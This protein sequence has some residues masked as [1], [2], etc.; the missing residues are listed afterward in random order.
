MPLLKAADNDTPR[1]TKGIQGLIAVSVALYY[2]Q[3]V[4]FGALDGALGYSV[5]RLEGRWWTVLTHPFVHGGFWQLLANMYALYLFGPRVESAWGTRRFL[6]FYAFCVLSGIIAHSALIHDGVPLTGA[7]AA[8]LGVMV[9]YAMLWPTDEVFVFGVL[10]V[11]VWTAVWSIGAAI[12]VAGMTTVEP[13]SAGPYLGYLVHLAG[14]VAGWA[15]MKTPGA[16]SLEQIRQRVS[17]VPDVEDPPRPIPRSP[18]RARERDETD[19]IVQRSRAMLAQQSTAH[20]APPK[21]VQTRRED[22]DRVLDKISASGID[23]LTES[24]RRTLEEMSRRLQGD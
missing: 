14:A 16:P 4:G 8:V 3:L 1:L 7:S 12:L 18:A 9:A 24:E 6:R 5:S 15:Y 21:P 13:G 19:E 23:S 11:R 20:V 17:R 2:L 10:P 22:L